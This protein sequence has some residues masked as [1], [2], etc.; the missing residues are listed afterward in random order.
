[1]SFSDFSLDGL[2]DI[3]R[4]Y[5]HVIVTQAKH[6]QFGKKT[7]LLVIWRCE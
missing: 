1:M 7:Q 3:G 6:F 4:K 2:T 5:S